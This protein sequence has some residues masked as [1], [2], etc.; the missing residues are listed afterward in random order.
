MSSRDK[1]NSVSST[2]RTALLSQQLSQPS[3]AS[4][5]TRYPLCGDDRASVICSKVHHS[6]NFEV[7]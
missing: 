4:E 3:R 5:L 6:T 1:H 7:M 2:R